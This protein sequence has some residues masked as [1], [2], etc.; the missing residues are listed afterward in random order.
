MRRSPAAASSRRSRGCGS[1]CRKAVRSSAAI[2]TARATSS[3][4]AAKAPPTAAARTSDFAASGRRNRRLLAAQHRDRAVDAVGRLLV[5]ELVLVAKRGLQAT[6][7]ML[8]RRGDRLMA[9][10]AVHVLQLVGIVH[11]VVELPLILL[12]EINQLVR[13]RANAV[14]RTRVVIA[15]IVVVAVVHRGAPVGRRA[16]AHERQEAP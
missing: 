15:R 8:A 14:V 10:K 5:R 12:P 11:E 3:A 2:S 1:P 6:Q 13:P 4:A 9:R 16:A 7:L